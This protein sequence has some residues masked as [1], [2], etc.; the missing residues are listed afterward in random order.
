MA[1]AVID[2]EKYEAPSLEKLGSFEEMTQGGFLVGLLDADY[3]AGTPS[4]QGLFS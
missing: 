4:S 3:P 2:L 1:L